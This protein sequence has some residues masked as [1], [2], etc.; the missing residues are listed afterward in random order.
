MSLPL[1]ALVDQAFGYCT[2]LHLPW[3]VPGGILQP[4]LWSLTVPAA[5]AAAVLMSRVLCAGTGR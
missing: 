3:C 2:Y 4:C 5:A 1:P